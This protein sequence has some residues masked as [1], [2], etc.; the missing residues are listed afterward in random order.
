M[1]IYITSENQ[2]FLKRLKV[3]GK[4]MSGAINK[5]LDE[6]RKGFNRIDKEMEEEFGE[7]WNKQEVSSVPSE[8]ETKIVTDSLPQL[9]VGKLCKH[10]AAKGFCKHFGCVNY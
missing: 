3:S 10:K 5:L 1:N 9:P 2:E 8:P 7:D 6:H 4:S